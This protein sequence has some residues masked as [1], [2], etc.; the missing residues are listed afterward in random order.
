MAHLRDRSRAPGHRWWRPVVE[1]AEDHVGPRPS[2]SAGRRRQSLRV[3]GLVALCLLLTMIAAWT[4]ARDEIRIAMDLAG[5]AGQRVQVFH[6]TD[7]RFDERHSA[8]LAVGPVAEGAAVALP[9]RRI[10][11]LR[12]DPPAGAPTLV[13]DLR[14]AGTPA[15]YRIMQADG[16]RVAR[17]G[18]CLE[19]Q[20]PAGAIDPRVVLRITGDAAGIAASGAGWHWASLW[21]LAGALAAGIAAMAASARSAMAL[22]RRSGV[23]R[24]Y[25]RADAHLHRIV[26]VAMLVFGIAYA[27]LTPPGA[28]PDEAAH[29]ARIIRIADGAPFGHGEG[30][31]FPDIHAM[32]GPFANYLSNRAPFQAARLRAQVARPLPCE[33]VTTALPHGADGY[34]PIHYV[35]AALAFRATC[36]AG[37]SF[38]MF[39]YL[40][41]GLDL[42]LATVL[43]VQGVRIA[44]RGRWALAAVSLLPMALF[45]MASISADSLALALAF[46][47]IGLISGLADGRV[48]PRRAR[49]WLA[50]LAAA[51]ALAKPGTAWVLAGLLLCGG[52]WRAAG[53]PFV[54][55]VLAYVVV[56]GVVHAA[57]ATFAAG[58]A[59]VLPGVDPAHNAAMLATEPGAVLAKILHSYTGAPLRVLYERTV[60][61]LGW[62]DV[63]LAG[64]AYTLAAAVLVATLCAGV[65]GRRPAA[66][67]HAIPVAMLLAAVSM[68]LVALP[69][70]IYWTPSGAPAV[71]G[72]QGRYM[73]ATLAFVLAWGTPGAAGPV[74][75]IASMV[76]LAG[77]A[78]LDIHALDRLHAAY[79]VTGR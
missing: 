62:L 31:R 72:I 9:R 77:L 73:L 71:A 70:F 11:W 55:A 57:L 51:L 54:P 19:L 64:W 27:G 69:L 5:P 16:M 6:A 52:A 65:P 79:Y 21:A 29:L 28:V 15:T 7:G 13:C 8:W 74:R 68:L 22:L 50:V 45:Q 4:H 2:R 32:Y 14:V 58:E 66:A 43:V 63:P 23:K 40:A 1:E 67:R 18:G 3:A 56:P 60:G 41:R 33:R 42:L 10:A 46:A 78:A 30:R 39:L 75:G 20:P 12:F 38:G 59:L 48:D 34:S 26:A 49:A 25:D 35:V 47:W 17:A 53:R 76:V 24:F 61:V 44:G 36:A 37:G